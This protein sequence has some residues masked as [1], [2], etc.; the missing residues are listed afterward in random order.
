MID[1]V[2]SCIT[3]RQLTAIQFDY[4]KCTIIQRIHDTLINLVIFFFK[5][6]ARQRSMD[7]CK[8]DMKIKITNLKHRHE[9]NEGHDLRSLV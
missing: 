5:M 6:D 7:Y 8:I 3:V 2:T 1:N 4:M 9:M